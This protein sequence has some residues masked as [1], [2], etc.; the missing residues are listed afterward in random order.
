[1]KCLFCQPLPNS[2]N[3]QDKRVTKFWLLLQT[4]GN[5]KILKIWAQPNVVRFP[6]QVLWSLFHMGGSA[7][8]R[9]VESTV[10]EAPGTKH[11]AKCAH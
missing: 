7:T 10:A 5:E 9:M 1:M 11:T 3:N 6:Q 8:Q 2:A 4:D